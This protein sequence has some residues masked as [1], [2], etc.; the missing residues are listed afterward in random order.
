MR[1]NGRSDSADFTEPTSDT[2]APALEM[3]AD[4]LRDGA[5]GADWHAKDHKIGACDGR[6]QR[7]RDLVSEPQFLN[8]LS[9]R[10]V[11]VGRD[12]RSRQ[13]ATPRSARDGGA[14]Q[15]KA[16]DRETIDYRGV[17]GRAQGLRQNHSPLMNFVSA[18]TT[19]SFASAVPIVIRRQSGKP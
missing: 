15:P 16:D 2:I 6:G 7:R 10:H 3:R 1:R 14:D 18:A 12:D 4:L 19:P 9:H 8:A 17:E 11:A 5:I 13:P